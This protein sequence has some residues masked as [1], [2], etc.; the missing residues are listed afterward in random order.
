MCDIENFFNNL[1][2]DVDWVAKLFKLFLLMSVFIL[3]SVNYLYFN[4]YKI[5]VRNI[6][7]LFSFHSEGRTEVFWEQLLFTTGFLF[8]IKRKFWASRKTG[9]GLN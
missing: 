3:I 5:N 9:D 4:S 7:I 8:T 2:N 1:Y 6:D